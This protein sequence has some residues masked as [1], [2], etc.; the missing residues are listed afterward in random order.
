VAFADRA[1]AQVGE[2]KVCSVHKAQARLLPATDTISRLECS[3]VAQDEAFKDGRMSQL[4]PAFD[5]VGQIFFKHFSLHQSQWISTTAL[6]EYST[7]CATWAH[8]VP[9]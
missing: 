6:C 5:R 9:E 1:L 8:R 3:A 7:L 2:D 4:L